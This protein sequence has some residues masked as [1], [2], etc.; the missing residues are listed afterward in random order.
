MG[1]PHSLNV[2]YTAGRVRFFWDF[3][4]VQDLLQG[5]FGEFLC[6][7]R[8]EHKNEVES[9]VKAEAY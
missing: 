4:T 3:K 5:L 1:I 9:C 6:I 7:D 2:W 8:N